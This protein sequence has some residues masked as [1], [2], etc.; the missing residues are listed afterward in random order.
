M[1]E[2]KQYV[3]TYI[4]E[5]TRKAQHQCQVYQCIM[6]SLTDT[7]RSRIVKKSNINNVR[8]RHLLH[9][10]VMTKISIDTRATLS[11]IRETFPSHGKSFKKKEC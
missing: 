7:A 2:I 8:C 5:E 1:D 3:A 4:N 11:H 6:N 10:I 9:K